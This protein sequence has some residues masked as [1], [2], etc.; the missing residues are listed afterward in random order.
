LGKNPTEYSDQTMLKY[1]RFRLFKLIQTPFSAVI[2]K[3]RMSVFEKI[4]QPSEGMR[5]LDLGGQPEIWDTVKPS[6][7][8][9]CINLPGIA[10]SNHPTHHEITYIEGDACSMPCFK[11]GEFDLIFSNSVIEHVGGQKKQ[12]QFADEVLRLSENY[13]IQTPSIYFPI[14]AHCGMPFWWLYPKWLRTYFLSRWSEKLPAWS[15]M[16]ATTTVLSKQ[17]VT[18]LFSGCKIKIEW[19]IFPKS[20]IAYSKN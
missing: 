17:Q 10:K 4:F 12:L 7:A 11:K 13:W 1:I 19:L 9:T 5:I 15:E 16:V 2:R 3:R 20:I 6:L 18:K 8:I 14:E